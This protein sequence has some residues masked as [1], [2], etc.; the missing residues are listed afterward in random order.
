MTWKNIQGVLTGELS[1]VGN[2]AKYSG[3]E[4]D[5]V[6]LNYNQTKVRPLNFKV[7]SKISSDKT[8]CRLF[9]SLVTP[10]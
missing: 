10:E 2:S 4:F 3:E 7:G 9:W 5:Q 8:L 1:D 6:H